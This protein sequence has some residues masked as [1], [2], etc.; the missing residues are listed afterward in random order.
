MVKIDAQRTRDGQYVLMHDPVLNRTTNVEAVFP[1]GPPGGPTREKRGGRDYISDYALA[2]IKRLRLVD[3]RDGGDHPVPTLQDALDLI[4]GRLLVA[5]DLKS[6]DLDSIVAL[7]KGRDTRNLL[8]FGIYYHDPTLLHDV[9]AAVGIRTFIAMPR[10]MDY[11]ADLKKL[12]DGL[13]P[14]LAMVSVRSRRLSPDVFAKARELGIALCISGMD[15]EDSDLRYKAD[16][17]PWQDALDSGAA[18]FM[19]D[20]PDALQKLLNR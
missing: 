6:Y 4:D 1:Q 13:G 15:D 14:L 12:A 2:D 10:S 18:A 3:G 5:L 20:E 11:A 19:T 17:G 8:F 9:A 7:L 16:P